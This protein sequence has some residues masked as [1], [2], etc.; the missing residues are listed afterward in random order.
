MKGILKLLVLVSLTALFLLTMASCDI[1]LEDIPPI[2]SW[3][4]EEETTLAP[5]CN[6]V[7]VIDAAVAPTCTKSGLTEGKHCFKCNEV[8]VAQKV[9]EALG[10][11]EV[12]DAAVEPTC[13]ESGLTVGVH[14]SVCKDVLVAQEEIS[15]HG[16]AMVTD[17]AVEPGCDTVGY[18]E[19]THCSICGEVEV[20]QQEI[21]A[22]GHTVYTVE[23]IAPTCTTAGVSEGKYC[24]DCNKV[25]VAPEMIPALGHTEVIDAA[26]D[27]TCTETGLT[28]GK[29]C[30]VCGVV[31]VAQNVIDALG[32]TEVTDAA[33]APTCTETGLTE[34]KHCS[35]CDTVLV[36]Q[37]VVDALGHDEIAHEAKAATCTED[38]YK[39][40]VTCSR[41]DYTTYEKVDALGHDE[42]THEAKAA[43]CTED[44]YKAYVTCSR[45]D[46]TTYEKVD[47]LG[48][49]EIAHEAKAATCTGDGYKAYVTCSRC[50][51]TTYEKVDALGH[52]LTHHEAKDP[53]CTTPGN[54]EY[55]ACSRC[56]YT[57]YVKIPV[58]GHSTVTVAK[59][60]ATCTEPGHSLY[61]KCT[62]CDYTRGYQEIPATGH[63]KVTHGAKA[64]DCTNVGNEAYETCSRCNYTTYVEIPALGHDKVTHEAK[65]PDCTN[66]G[67]EAYETCTRC[68]YTTYVEIP[69]LGH[70]KVTHEAKTPDCTNVGNEAYETCSRCNY[71]TY[72]EIPSLGHDKVAHE[73]KAPDC[74][75]VGNEAYET[76]SRCN[77]TTYVEIPALGHDEVA[78]EAKA[79]DCTNVGNEAYVTCTRCDY[80]A[81]YVEIP[82]LGHN[83]HET[84]YKCDTCKQ[85]VAPAADE[86]LNLK[87]ANA[88]GL[89]HAK[90]T[91][92]T[93]K[94]YITGVI[95]SIASTTYGNVY[96]QDAEGNTFYIYG[97]WSYDGKTRYN[98]L[99]TKPGVG[100]EITV[101]GVIGTFDTKSAQMKDGWI[102]DFV[103]CE[104]VYEETERVEATCEKDGSITKVCSICKL[105]TITEKIPPAGHK[106][107]N[108]KCSICGKGE[109]VI[110]NVATFDFGANGSAAH[111]DGNAFG[112]T[113]SYTNDGY[114][115]ALTGLSKVYGPAYDAKGNS[116]IKLGTGSAAG[117]FSFTV[118]EDVT[119]VIIYVAK[120]KTNTSKINVNGTAYTISGASNNGVY[121]AIEIDTTTTKTVTFKTVSGGYRVM[122]NTIEFYAEK[123]V[124]GEVCTHNYTETTVPATCTKDGSIT[125]VCSLCGETD[126]ETL[127]M[128]AHT[129]V[130]GKCSGCE[131]PQP[132]STLTIPEANALGAKQE[133]YT[134]GKYYVTGVVKS[135]SH[136]TYGNLYI[137]DEAG[138]TLY[139]YGLYSADGKIRFDAMATKPAVGDTITVYG[140]VGQYNKTPQI[141][142]GWMTTHTPAEDCEHV[143]E[144]IPAVPATCTETG[145][146][147]GTKCSKCDDILTKQE[148]I[149]ALGHTTD[150]GTCERCGEEITGAPAEPEVIATFNLGANGSASHND[151]SGSK[152]TYSET[153][154]GYTLSIT[155]GT[156]LY[157]GARD[158]KGNSALKLGTS[159]KTG[160]FTF[161]V[162][163]NVNK[164]VIYV[165]QYKTNTTKVTVNDQTYTITTASNNGAYTPIEIDTS[166]TKTVTFATVSG[167]LR[168]MVNT[169]E[170]WS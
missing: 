114:T 141:Q 11:T 125:K 46:Y 93:G 109:T 56:D 131:L 51:Y 96:I 135:I 1:L 107:E 152:A 8:L 119:K 20:A 166:T 90:N 148:T 168:A 26:V 30:S 87:Q 153:A 3:G 19:G 47:A 132:D 67:N 5:E 66:V 63:D 53:S 100:D 136:T 58:L 81:N 79:P 7:V 28:E 45:C 48:H 126:I 14:C 150:N 50:D 55:D 110:E 169:I 101:W 138:N 162:D 36:A 4:P 16:H 43:T 52:D 142:N 112:S 154:D 147:A 157:T 105:N 104:H 156:N 98:A 95:T 124:G 164:V 40:Y 116:C 120:Y 59:K 68:N 73:A 115:L 129:Y 70:D 144:T 146:T 118:P 29:H 18:T 35:V 62:R 161:T 163:E 130:D 24:L 145:L 143:E 85:V 80:T 15:A 140:I 159:K 94:Y 23:A 92:T 75:N 39:A 32:H 103:V 72:V 108:G 91:Y 149:A 167:A 65:A 89:A 121:D 10:H 102:D 82:A 133:S 170:F 69:A 160:S 9:I 113:K 33:V 123:E 77:Y 151:G 6:H 61:R 64:P 57:T 117:S 37:T 71:T 31:L 111:V 12:I 106:Y 22:L 42:I 78:H 137:Q 13:T 27:P 60:D 21:P 139:I 158:A 76:C 83:G 54:K 74:T 84:D 2:S 122:I 86:T 34:G 88:L 99:A 97:L 25:L 49:D 155:G 17:I 44:G 128:I 165:A 127:P 134:S 38:G 41:C